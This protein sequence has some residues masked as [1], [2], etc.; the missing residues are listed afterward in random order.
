VPVEALE[1]AFQRSQDNLATLVPG[2]QNVIAT[3]SG[4]FGAGR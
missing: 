1:R 3:K 4:H 2:I